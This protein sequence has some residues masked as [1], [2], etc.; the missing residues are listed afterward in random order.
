[1]AKLTDDRFTAYGSEQFAANDLV[2]NAPRVCALPFPTYAVRDI[3]DDLTGAV[4]LH[5][6]GSYRF[7][8]GAYVRAARV[9][10]ADLA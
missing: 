3:R 1:M 4:F 7:H 9:V 6:L 8:N 5:F 2:A 10:I